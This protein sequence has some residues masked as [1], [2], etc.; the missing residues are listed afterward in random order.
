M[1]MIQTRALTKRYGGIV[2]VDDL[3]FDVRPGQVTALLGPNG[4][5]KST[6]L[7]LMLDLERGGGETRYDGRRYRRLSRP[8]IEVGACVGPPA[9]HPGRRVRAHL[10]MLAAAGRIPARR[11][12]GVLDLVGLT[13]VAGARVRVLS[14]GALGRLALASALLG[15]PGTLIL[16]EPATGLDPQGVRWLRDFLRAYAADGRTVLVAGHI[17]AETAN[18]ADRVLVIS[19]GR[20]VADESAADFRRRG[21]GEAVSVRTPQVA[22]LSALLRSEGVHTT[23]PGG[24]TLTAIGADRARVGE[25]AFRGGILLHELLDRP[26]ALGDAFTNALTRTHARPQPTPEAEAD[27]AATS[28]PR[29]THPSATSAGDAPLPDAQP[30][31]VLATRPLVTDTG[32]PH[33][34]S[35]EAPA[36]DAHPPEAPATDAEPADAWPIRARS[37]EGWATG[38][39][40]TEVRASDVRPMEAPATDALA[41]DPRSMDAWPGHA[42]RTKVQATDGRLT[43][44]QPTE[45]PATEAPATEALASD[46]GPTAA[47][48]ADACSVEGLATGVRRTTEVP[49]SDAGPTDAR[50][51]DA[52]SVEGLATGARRATE[53][54][55]GDA[56]L[57][58]VSAAEA[59][60][61]GARS[62]STRPADVASTEVLTT[63]VPP[64]GAGP[65]HRSSAEA[66]V[67]DARSTEDAAADVWSGGERPASE[68]SESEVRSA[69]AW[70]AETWSAE[71]RVADPRLTDPR[72]ADP[73]SPDLQPI[74]LRSAEARRTDARP[75]ELRPGGSRSTDPRPADAGPPDPRPADPRPVDDV[76]PVDAQ[77][78]NARL[79][80]P[81]PPDPGSVDGWP[82]EPQAEG[83]VDGGSSVEVAVVGEAGPEGSVEEA[84]GPLPRRRRFGRTWR[85]GERS[86]EVKSA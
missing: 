59:Q 14:A 56:R 51:A 4:A 28:A 86:D 55:A 33:A 60:A 48:W 47:R 13:P 65:A 11:V 37:T 41:T 25:I 34:R 57:A 76:Q 54:P 5:G 71:T 70:S 45:A 17:L 18:C 50:R 27:P 72:P 42:R 10:R 63:V 35:T 68:V 52:R 2:A 78:T 36:T 19:R 81:R 83:G 31:E 7:R 39:R 44:A 23:R 58:D 6:T 20:L 21:A 46:A 9:A 61:G 62:T 16:D 75:A 38:A 80:D 3:S 77:P 82:G 67:V 85:V 15:D 40:Q 74:D 12:D 1:A 43:G 69:E 64:A 53:L 32:L 26:P 8:G 84:G 66:P 22:R 29:P 73:R 30:T 49:A 24:T 79:A